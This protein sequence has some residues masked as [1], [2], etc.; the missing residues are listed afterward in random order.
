MWHLPENTADQTNSKKKCTISLFSV[1]SSS[2]GW[3]RVRIPNWLPEK[4][5]FLWESSISE[6]P[7]FRKSPSW[8]WVVGLRPSRRSCCGPCCWRW[9][10]G[11]PACP[12][13]GRTWRGRPGSRGRG[14]RPC[15]ANA[16]FRK[17]IFLKWEIGFCAVY[18][19]KI[20]MC[21]KKIL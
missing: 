6:F 2:R 21:Q 7:I 5:Y 12:C 18:V 11:T 1:F 4:Y 14:Q 17:F 10:L 15:P 20:F 13:A 9:C 8:G 3:P 19:F 16:R